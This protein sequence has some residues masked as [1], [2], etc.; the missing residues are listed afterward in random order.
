MSNEEEIVVNDPLRPKLGLASLQLSLAD[1]YSKHPYFSD[2]TCQLNVDERALVDFEESC[3]LYVRG[4]QNATL[5]AVEKALDEV[6]RS[7]IAST[8]DVNLLLFLRELRELTWDLT[9]RDLAFLHKSVRRSQPDAVNSAIASERFW[10]GSLTPQSVAAILKA[11]RTDL[12]ILRERS[13]RGR[14]TREELSINSG[15]TVRKVARLLKRDFRDQGV[16][17]NLSPILPGRPRITGLA[18]ELSVAGSTWWNNGFT[19]LDAPGTMYAHVDESIEAP[20]AIVYLTDVHETNGPTGFYPR[21]YEQ[22]QLSYL[23]D[24]IGRVLGQVGSSKTSPLHAYYA[25][26]Y[27]QSMSSARFRQHFMALP[28]QLRFNSHFGWDLH[29]SAQITQEMVSREVLMTGA[30]G[31]YV[32]FDGARLVHRGGLIQEGERVALQVVFGVTPQLIRLIRGRLS[33]LSSLLR[34][35]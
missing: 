2:K 32:V 12:A 7:M 21:I 8:E 18:I 16:F 35:K 26:S 3:R 14:R 29:P 34:T 31:T 19:N 17:R 28:A 27:H 33:R 9:K 13:A 22:L 6:F 1:S 11:T 5:R 4:H 24:V 10:F 25:G 23:Q 20:K 30:P 15:R